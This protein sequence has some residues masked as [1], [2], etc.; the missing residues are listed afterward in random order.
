MSRTKTDL[1]KR[2]PNQGET[3]Q[4]LEG[5]GSKLSGLS[6]SDAWVAATLSNARTPPSDWPGSDEEKSAKAGDQKLWTP[7]DANKLK[8]PNAGSM[9][10]SKTERG[11]IAPP[12]AEALVAVSSSDQLLALPHLREHSGKESTAFWNLA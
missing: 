6:L 11:E 7:T 4:L 8:N 2:G 9:A 3:A 1:T 12:R 5:F 10:K